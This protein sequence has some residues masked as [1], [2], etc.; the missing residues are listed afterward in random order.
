[1]KS[2]LT[3]LIA[4]LLFLL[5]AVLLG[6]QAKGAGPLPGDLEFTRLLQ[7]AVPYNDSVK[8]L[9]NA[10]G[11]ILRYSPYVAIVIALLLRKWDWALLLALAT[12][13]IALFGESQL[14]PIFHRSRPTADL[15]A[16]YQVSKGTG[17]PSGTALQAMALV[18][19]MLYLARLSGK[20]KISIAVIVVSVVYLLLSN[21]ARVHVGAHWATDIV[22]GWLFASAWLALLLAGHQWWLDRQPDVEPA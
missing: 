18:G 9:W 10:L 17:F 14:K 16:I 11:E 7:R 22:G 8:L 3:F 20:S 1:M 15:V 4:A 21:L 12:M 6:L 5:G 19:T 13:P 2:Y